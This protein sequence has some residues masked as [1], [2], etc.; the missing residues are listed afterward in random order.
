MLLVLVAC[1][2]PTSACSPPG[3]QAALQLGITFGLGYLMATANACYRDFGLALGPA[4]NILM[5]TAPV[6]YATS[7]VP[8]SIEN[9][10]LANPMAAAIESYRAGLLGAVPV[11]WASLAT[12]A[13][14]AAL[15]CSSA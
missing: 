3:E 13:V 8:R 15:C 9:L 2:S 5:F 12:A 4:L 10:F 7:L 1:L 11:P 6:V 14:V